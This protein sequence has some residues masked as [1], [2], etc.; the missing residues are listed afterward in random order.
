MVQDDDGNDAAPFTLGPGL[1]VT[2]SNGSA[3]AAGVPGAPRALA[4]EGTGG[5]RIG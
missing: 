4:A 2:V 3:V 5:D 1:S